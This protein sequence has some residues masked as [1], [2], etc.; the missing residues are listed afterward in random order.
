MKILTDYLITENQCPLWEENTQNIDDIPFWGDKYAFSQHHWMKTLR[1]FWQRKDYDL[2]ITG[3]FRGSLLYAWLQWIFPWHKRPQLMLD[4]MLDEKQPSL[5]W[6][7]KRQIQKRLLQKVDRILIF[8]RQELEEYSRL[9][10][11]PQNKFQFVYYHTNIIEPHL[12]SRHGGYIFAA[13]NAGRDYAT[14]L[15]ALEGTDI[16]TIIVTSPANLAGLKTPPSVKVFYNIPYDKYLELLNNARIVVVPLHKRVRSVGMVV[17]MEGM[18]LGKP[19]VVSCACSLKEYIEDGKNGFM[20][21]VNDA[22]ALRE[23]IFYL[24]DNPQ[25]AA[26][27]GTQA[28]EDI[29]NRWTFN[30]YVSEVLKI[31]REMVDINLCGIK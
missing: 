19:V 9:L 21:E 26:R 5:I 12:V 14:L 27:I 31:A 3:H 6:Q 11:I 1:L 29:K 24:L 15:K 28:L 25:E 2:I 20:V 10:D 4:F 13:G 18:A 23:K 7:I 16:P 17:M 22:T 30:H 8:S